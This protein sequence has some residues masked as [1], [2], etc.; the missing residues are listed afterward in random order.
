MQQGKKKKMLVTMAEFARHAG[1]DRSTVS[2]M[3]RA[4]RLSTV[5]GRIDLEKARLEFEK[6]HDPAWDLRRAAAKRGD[7]RELR[8]NSDQEISADLGYYQAHALREQV[9]AK[10]LMLELKKREGKLIDADQV[11]LAHQKVFSTLRAN[12]RGIPRRLASRLAAAK[13]EAECERLITEAIDAALKRTVEK[14][15]GKVQGK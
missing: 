4:G 9:Q 12:L 1:V 15:F 10:L 14:P 2:R 8:V 7:V 6:G 3:V 11:L 5:A 13:K